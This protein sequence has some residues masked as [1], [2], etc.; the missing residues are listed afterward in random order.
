MHTAEDDGESVLISATIDTEA[1]YSKGM[2]A[3][4][5]L[6]MVEQE[7]QSIVYVGQE[8]LSRRVPITV[9]ISEPTRWVAQRVREQ[10][11]G[12]SDLFVDP[13][14]LTAIQAWVGPRVVPNIDAGALQGGKVS[15]L[16]L[17]PRREETRNR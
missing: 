14:R 1:R 17:A 16:E 2:G 7:C 13:P 10:R 11:V 3:G 12:T 9:W 4:S 5:H 15:N 6:L 8:R